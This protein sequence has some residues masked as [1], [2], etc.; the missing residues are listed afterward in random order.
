MW[1]DVH[2]RRSYES[3]SLVCLAFCFN[4]PLYFM[5]TQILLAYS[6]RC[7][8]VLVRSVILSVQQMFFDERLAAPG[9]DALFEQLEKLGKE[10]VAIWNTKDAGLWELRNSQHVHTFSACV[11]ASFVCCLLTVPCLYECVQH[12][13]GF[14]WLVLE[15]FMSF[16]VL[17]PL[18]LNAYAKKE[19]F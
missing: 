10:A 5:G 4:L 7:I 6:L 3:E 9:T 2:A 13:Q 1:W 11:D 17:F 14:H 12:I 15:A 8:D 18:V 16:R 19:R